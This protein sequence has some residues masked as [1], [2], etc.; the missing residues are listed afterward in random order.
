MPWDSS[1][2][3]FIGDII[4][5]AIEAGSGSKKNPGGCII[6]VVLVVIVIGVILYYV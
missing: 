4:G 2:T 1:D 5:D 3:D 6:L